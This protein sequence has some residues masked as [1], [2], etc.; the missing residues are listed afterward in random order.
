MYTLKD[1]YPDINFNVETPPTMELNELSDRE[2]KFMATH[3]DILKQ[4]NTPN[5]KLKFLELH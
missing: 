1:K 3:A 5:F 4:L 2:I